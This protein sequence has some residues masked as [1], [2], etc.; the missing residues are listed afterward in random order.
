MRAAL[1]GRV[2]TDKQA[3]KYGIPSQIEALRKRCLERE[4]TLVL[5]GDKD[6]FVD[7][8]Y[9]GTELD[10]PTLDRLRQAAREGRVEMSPLA[11]AKPDDDRLVM[12]L[13]NQQSIRE[14]I[15]FPQLREKT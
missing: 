8:G 4:W 2:S 13:T 5:D 11:K 15:L 7:D 6:V 3:E 1:Y 12:L 9:S 10:R 14:I